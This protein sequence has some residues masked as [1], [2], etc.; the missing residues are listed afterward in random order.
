MSRLPPSLVAIG[1]FDGVH[2]G[3]RAVLGDALARA[4]AAQLVPRVLTFSPHPA[5]VLGHGAPATL[6]RLPNKIR[7]LNEV[8]FDVEVQPFD[9]TFA[10]LSP[11]DFARQLLVERLDARVIVVGQNFRFGH[12]RAG[13]LDTLRA[14]GSQLGFEVFPHHLVGDTNGVWSSTRV[15]KAIEVGDVAEAR[16]IMGRD[17]ALEGVVEHGQHRA[18]GLGFPT[19]NLG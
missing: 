10:A 15:R 12:R 5:E 17:H 19:A 9:R 18:R 2:R 4:H 7:L 1:N 11:E 14:L 8:G 3:H 13:D 6:T 16:A